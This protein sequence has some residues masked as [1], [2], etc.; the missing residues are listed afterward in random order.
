MK[1]TKG[2]NGKTK[3]K[4]AQVIWKVLSQI[5][6]KQINM[7]KLKQQH[8]FKVID[9]WNKW[10]GQMEKQ[11]LNPLRS[12]EKSWESNCEKANKYGQN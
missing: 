5:L 12:S 2:T 3:F 4:S 11:N 6:N 9:N 10:K 8:I 1:Q 7:E